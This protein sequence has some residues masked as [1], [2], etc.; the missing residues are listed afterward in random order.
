MS[1]SHGSA[2]VRTV[3]L[4]GV[5]CAFVLGLSSAIAAPKPILL[6][7]TPGSAFAE[8]L[9]HNRAEAAARTVQ[10]LPDWSG[11]PA[12]ATIAS[13]YGALFEQGWRI[14]HQ[15]ATVR[16]DPAA[17]SL[18]AEVTATVTVLDPELK[19][20][21]LRS[22]L[23]EVDALQVAAEVSVTT[24]YEPQFGQI[25]VITMT[26]ALPLAVGSTFS[27]HVRY[28]ATLDCDKKTS[29]LRTCTFDADFAQVLFFRYFLDHT[30]VQHS[31]YTTLLHVVTPADKVAAAPGTPLGSE[32]LPSG[33]LLWS[34]QQ[35]ERTE[36]GGISIASYVQ[37][38]TD[39]TTAKPNEPWLRLLTLLRRLSQNKLRANSLS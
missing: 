20:I 31:P 30:M 11:F 34:F 2:Q 1:R 37:T 36:N 9:A 10:P 39:P 16:I 32:L 22:E 12:G 19:T 33:E 25:G 3:W 18:S 5:A 21:A 38:G 28:H 29:L 6:P 8:R 7:P 35:D 23:V 14:E 15:E 4:V 13:A 24:S 17:S 27:V 26:P